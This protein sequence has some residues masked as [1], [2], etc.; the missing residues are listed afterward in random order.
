MNAEDRADFE[1]F[2]A[3][4]SHALFRTALTLT[5][6]R[7]QAE[8]LL[9]TALVRTV[10][11]WRRVRADNPE[12]Y[13]RT[14]MYRQQLNWWRQRGR[15][16]ETPLPEPPE[17]GA[18]DDTAAVDQRL[19]IDSALRRLAPRHRAVLTLRYLEDLPV[20]AAAEI[21]GCTPSTVRS[22]TVRALR[23]LREL[24]PELDLRQNEGTHR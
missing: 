16:P 6:H 18:A 2:V 10:R 1:A 5:G 14:I 23:R 24:C 19:L 22:Q 7:Q 8:D 20:E 3:A 17:R 9:Q 21:L 15:R 11:H 12:A 4:R 13:L